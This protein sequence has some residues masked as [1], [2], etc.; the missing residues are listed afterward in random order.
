MTAVFGKKVAIG[1]ENGPEVDVLVY[2]DEHYA[3]YEKPD[4]YSVIYDPSV[5]L[6]CYAVLRDGRFESSGVP[7]TENPPPGALKHAEEAPEVRQAKV[8]AKLAARGEQP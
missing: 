1:Q 6:F 5:G 4:G 8:A 2:G 3:R 7:M